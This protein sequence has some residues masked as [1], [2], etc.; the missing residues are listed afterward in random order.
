MK[1]IYY[2]V[3]DRSDEQI[4][5]FKNRYELVS[6][7]DIIK[8]FNINWYTVESLKKSSSW[9]TAHIIYYI[10]IVWRN[11]RLV[12]RSNS[13]KEWWFN[14]PEVVM[15]SEKI[16]TDIVRT[17]WVKTNNIIHVD[18]SRKDFSFDYQIEEELIWVDPEIYLNEDENF[19]DTKENY[20]TLSYELW[21][22][23][24]KY[25][26]LKFDWFWL[27]NEDKIL[28]WKVE[29]TNNNFY[30]YI[31][32][33]LNL[34]LNFLFDNKVIDNY[35]LI[36]VINIFQNNKNV[37][38]NCESCL[39]HHD[40]ADHNLIYDTDSKWLWA[41]FDWEAM[42]L[43]DPMLDLW[44]CPTWET[45]YERKEI[46]IEW[47]K[48]IKKL[49]EDYKL[50]MNLYELRTLIWKIMFSIRMNFDKK[51]IEKRIF[52]MKSVINKF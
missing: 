45:H 18:I 51:V 37:I 6:K 12:F 5:S 31:T 34:H 38:N 15:L 28:K 25:S 52:N 4:N 19:I 49:P 24:A 7:E 14:K 44:S 43:G 42:V 33:N 2:K 30:D 11:T 1:D 21:Q 17:L 23:I 46:L 40:L 50:R 48:S 9:W 32:T 16:I 20:D 8:V 13:W 22:S 36:K 29:W 35:L 10:K 27:L 39:I 26:E 41:I 47:Y 3:A